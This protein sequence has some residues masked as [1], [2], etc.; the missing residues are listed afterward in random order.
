MEETMNNKPRRIKIHKG[1]TLVEILVVVV[2]IATLASV[3]AP[4]FTTMRESARVA[5]IEAN[6]LTIRTAASMFQADNAGETITGLDNLAKYMLGIATATMVN[7]DVKRFLDGN[8]K[9]ATYSFATQTLTL[10]TRKTLTITLDDVKDPA[11]FADRPH[12]APVN[13][14]DTR[15]TWEYNF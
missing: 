6:L 13:P 11:R 3:A 14:G 9:G 10:S 12:V 8:P 5:A 7:G 4:R 15:L 1:F 2:I